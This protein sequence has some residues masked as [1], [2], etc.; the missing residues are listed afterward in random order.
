MLIETTRQSEVHGKSQLNVILSEIKLLRRE[1]KIGTPTQQSSA[2]KSFAAA[3]AKT[4]QGTSTNPITT[5]QATIAK[6]H[7]HHTNGQL[8]PLCIEDAIKRMFRLTVSAWK[9]LAEERILQSLSFENMGLREESIPEAHS[10]TFRWI[11]EAKDASPEYTTGRTKFIEWLESQSNIFWVSGKAGSGKSTLMKFL[12]QHKSTIRHLHVWA[13]ASTRLITASYYFWSAGSP[14]QKSLQGLLQSLIYKIFTVCPQLMP[15]VCP[16]R[17][18]LGVGSA[19]HEPWSTNGLSD[20]KKQIPGADFARNDFGRKDSAWSIGELSDTMERIKQQSEISARFCFFIDGLDEY[21][22]Y[23]RDVN[24]VLRGFSEHPNIKICLSSRPWNVF[25]DVF[26]QDVSCKFYLHDMSKQDIEHYV[27]G[28]LEVHP[29]F[30]ASA[31]DVNYVNLVRDTVARS[32]GVF[33]WVYLVVRSLCDGLD[34]YDSL[35][36]LRARLDSI[37]T[38]LDEFFHKIIDSIDPVYKRTL[39][40]TFAIALHAEKPLALMLYSVLEDPP[41]KCMPLSLFDIRQRNTTMKRQINGKSKGLLEVIFT[42]SK[43]EFWGYHVD[44]LHRTLRDY[45]RLHAMKLHLQQNVRSDFNADF[46]LATSALGLIRVLAHLDENAQDLWELRRQFFLHTCAFESQSCRA[47]IRLQAYLDEFFSEILKTRRSSVESQADQFHKGRMISPWQGISV[48][49]GS[50]NVYKPQRLPEKLS[51][52]LGYTVIYGVLDYAI[53]QLK[54]DPLV[55]IDMDLL[56]LALGPALCDI[57]HWG[58]EALPAQ[59]ESSHQ[60]NKEVV[61]LLAEHNASVAVLPAY[62]SVLAS[63]PLPSS[64]LP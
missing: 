53:Q 21:E 42:P 10:R 43:R 37:P 63:T 35:A 50:G 23:H 45:L 17:W 62:L 9:F 18:M 48:A 2:S 5:S 64:R 57:G 14:M 54:E 41:G 19:N 1:L 8:K 34:N 11:F 13:P 4:S 58:V 49:C 32:Q 55:T 6:N 33:L 39:S 46:A 15:I 36:I 25:K 22:G 28:K 31:K 40:E 38:D 52:M 3:P 16:S 26:G 61:R 60:Y 29:N 44:F 27:K 30:I 56:L 7:S 59:I 20:T 12:Y 24:E 51:Y 47:G